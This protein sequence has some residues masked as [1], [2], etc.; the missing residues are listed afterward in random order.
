MR[1]TSLGTMATL[2]GAFVLAAC[3]GVTISVVF[4]PHDAKPR[5]VRPPAARAPQPAAAAAP[6]HTYA[7][8]GLGSLREA[9]PLTP[10][11]AVHQCRL[12]IDGGTFPDEPFE[13]A[14]F[15]RARRVEI[16]GDKTPS[17]SG[18][19]RARHRAVAR[20][21]R[22]PR[23][24]PAPGSGA[25]PARR[26]ARPGARGRAAR[27]RPAAAPPGTRAGAQAAPGRAPAHL[28][29]LGLISAGRR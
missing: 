19:S 12:V 3:V 8:A 22:A 10:L 5:A 9:P 6:A 7:V 28:R 24:G 26:R 25:R 11:P 2:V 18:A 17:G 4:G 15:D 20:G 21:R 1:R 23:P 27:R 16:R 14:H 13:P 29:R